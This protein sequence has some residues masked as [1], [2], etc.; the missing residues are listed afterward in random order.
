MDAAQRISNNEY[1]FSDEWDPA[2]VDLLKAAA[3]IRV[4]LEAIPKSDSEVTVEDFKSFWAMSKENT[5]SSKNE[6]HFGHYH[7][8]SDN[9]ELMALHV[10]SINLAVQRGMPLSHWWQGVKASL[11]KIAITLR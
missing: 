4:E 11:E 1:I 9:P 3:M 8:V 7:A 5:S 10:L 6:R 2:T